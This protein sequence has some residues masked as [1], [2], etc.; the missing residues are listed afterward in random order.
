[1]KRWDAAGGTR[2]HNPQLWQCVVQSRTKSEIAGLITCGTCQRPTLY[3][4]RFEQAYIL[5]G[6]SKSR[7]EE[8]QLVPIHAQDAMLAFHPI[9]SIGD[10]PI[11]R[12]IYD[13]CELMSTVDG[14]Y[15]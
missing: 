15:G 8:H 7:K 4:C 1:V 14:G 10:V 3:A 6:K 11:V 12:Q 2:K 9:S 5:E 13:A